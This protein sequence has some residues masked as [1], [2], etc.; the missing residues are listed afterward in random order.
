MNL[1][2]LSENDPIEVAKQVGSGAEISDDSYSFFTEGVCEAALSS[3]KIPVFSIEEIEEIEEIESKRVENTS[4]LSKKVKRTGFLQNIFKQVRI[5]SPSEV[6]RGA[7]LPFL[8]HLC[9]Q[10]QLEDSFLREIGQSGER[11]LGLLIL[12]VITN[13]LGDQSTTQVHEEVHI[14]I[15]EYGISERIRFQVVKEILRYMGRIGSSRE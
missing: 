14:F 3:D 6:Q 5:S 8:R 1:I 12:W 10:L 9:R 11:D 4:A 7:A 2:D 15:P 13:K